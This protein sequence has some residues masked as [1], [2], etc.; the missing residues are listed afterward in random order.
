MG[1]ELERSPLFGP[2]TDWALVL[3]LGRDDDLVD[4]GACGADLVLLR[5]FEFREDTSS[6]VNSGLDAVRPQVRDSG[7]EDLSVLGWDST[8]GGA[9]ICATRGGGEE[10]TVAVLQQ[11]PMGLIRGARMMIG[12]Y[13]R[14]RT[15]RYAV[16]GYK[17]RR[18]SSPESSTSH[19]AMSRKI[20]HS[21]R[22][23]TICH[24][25]MEFSLGC[26]SS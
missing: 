20:S 5:V 3:E 17:G 9:A 25:V 12:R 1:L 16:S 26:S 23:Q 22:P 18:L 13:S 2:R 15:R 8:G 11:F 10:G 7:T 4:W 24:V 21:W 6:C 19:G 14:E